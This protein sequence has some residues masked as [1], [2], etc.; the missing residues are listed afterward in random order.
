MRNLILISLVVILLN[1]CTLLLFDSH[2][3]LQ[4]A[5]LTV[6]NLN[7][8]F[9]NSDSSYLYQT[10]IR[11]MKNY[12][13]G[14]MVI[15]PQSDS[16]TRAV[17]VTEMGVK[18]FDFEVRNPLLFK[19]FYKV[20]YIIDPMSKK[21]IT[22]ALANDIGFLCQNGTVKYV[23]AFSDSDRAVFRIRNKCKRYF[24]LYNS[25][26]Q[27]YC[28]LKVNSIL[29]KKAQVNFYGI[30]NTAPD[31]IKIQHFGVNLNYVFR[32]IKQ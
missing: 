9:N 16:I 19:K 4:K 32:K 3:K 22:N 12:Y 25:N 20:N 28:E 2:K 31:S 23:D 30:N 17:F 6:K 1:S 24:Y 8:Y 21:V 10:E 15:K 11:F 29:F 27:K 5:N 13:S 26:E 14:L 18:I 7:S